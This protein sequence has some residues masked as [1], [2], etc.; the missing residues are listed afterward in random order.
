MKKMYIAIIA[1]I[2]ISSCKKEQ[3]WQCV[4]TATYYM[5]NTD[6]VVDKKTSSNVVCDKTEGKIKEYQNLKAEETTSGNLRIKK[7][8]T[9]T[10]K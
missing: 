8:T 10:K 5:V 7:E 9:C 4:D 6:S 3:C 2:A 1:I